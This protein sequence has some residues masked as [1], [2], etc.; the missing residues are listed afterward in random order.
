[1]ENEGMKGHA[2]KH[3]FIFRSDAPEFRAD[4]MLITLSAASDLRWRGANG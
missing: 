1:M 3:L 4:L 2:L